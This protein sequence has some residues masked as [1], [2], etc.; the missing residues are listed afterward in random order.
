MKNL[1]HLSYF[2]RLEGFSRKLYSVACSPSLPLRL[3]NFAL[4]LTDVVSSP[5]E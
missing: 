1:S 3:R 4:C 5:N 2:S